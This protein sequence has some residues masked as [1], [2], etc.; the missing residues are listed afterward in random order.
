MMPLDE[1]FK[2]VKEIAPYHGRSRAEMCADLHSIISK[3]YDEHKSGRPMI[4]YPCPVDKAPCDMDKCKMLLKELSCK[5]KKREGAP[6]GFAMK[7]VD[8]ALYAV[9]FWR[10]ESSPRNTYA[11]LSGKVANYSVPELINMLHERVY[12]IYD[13]GVLE[14]RELYAGDMVWLI[15]TWLIAHGIDFHD[16]I[17]KR[18]QTVKEGLVSDNEYSE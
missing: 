16:L 12:C 15:Q 6:D 7:L 5:H 11:E 17:D 13:T 9:S 10:S 1:I 8:A 3:A 2:E 18:W 14:E 4:W